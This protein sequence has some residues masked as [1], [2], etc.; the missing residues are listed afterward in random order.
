[1]RTIETLANSPTQDTLVDILRGSDERIVSAL[2]KA[3]A[4][5]SASETDLL[6]LSRE[7]RT[8]LA[9]DRQK[10]ARLESQQYAVGNLVFLLGADNRWFWL[11]G[12]LGCCA[13]AG[14][15]CHERRRELRRRLNGGRA[16]SMGLAHILTA[17][18]AILAWPRAA[19]SFSPTRSRSGSLAS[20]PPTNPA[21]SRNRSKSV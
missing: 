18:L 11:F 4:E 2:K 5:V 3:A 15:V 20:C 21:K 17:L 14:I 1:M 9:R 16:R 6:N 8:A 12:L 19:P 10:P 13:L 7:V